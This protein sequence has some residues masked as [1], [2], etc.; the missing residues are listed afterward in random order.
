M[1]ESNPNNHL[2]FIVPW[3]ALTLK[4]LDKANDPIRKAEKEGIEMEERI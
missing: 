1:G 2:V 4:V 3:G